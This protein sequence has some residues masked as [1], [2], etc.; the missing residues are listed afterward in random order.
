MFNFKGR[1]FI[2]TLYR[3]FSHRPPHFFA[4]HFW[5]RHSCTSL[6]CSIRAVTTLHRSKRTKPYTAL[7]EQK[8]KKLDQRW[9]APIHS[10]SVL[11][12]N[13]VKIYLFKSTLRIKIRRT[14]KKLE[15]ILVLERKKKKE[16]KKERPCTAR[17]EQNLAPLL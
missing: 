17:I 8:R 3:T 2:T 4:Q 6:V 11:S 16:R 9:Q 14:V 5:P 10:K 1:V 15:T 12:F 13:F 7:I